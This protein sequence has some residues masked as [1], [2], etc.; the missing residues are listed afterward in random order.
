MTFV[1]NDVGHIAEHNR[2][3]GWPD[4]VWSTF[5]PSLQQSVSLATSSLSAEYI[6]T[7]KS[8]KGNLIASIN[9][10]G[11]AANQIT[12]TLP[13]APRHNSVPFTIGAFTYLD[14]SPGIWYTG[15]VTFLGTGAVVRFFCN[16]QTDVFGKTPAVTAATGDTLAFSFQ[17]EAA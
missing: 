9:S 3:L 7:G 10:A 1:A 6:Q 12:A 15:S 16:A 8:V 14:L 17:Y 2:L 5:T 13:V 4:G 11:T